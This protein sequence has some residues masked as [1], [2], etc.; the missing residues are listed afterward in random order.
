L[1][2]DLRALSTEIIID[3]IRRMAANAPVHAQRSLA[4][5]RSFFAWALQN[6][7]I[8]ENPLSAVVSPRPPP[9]R[10]RVLGLTEVRAVWRAAGDLGL[11]FGA[12]IALLVLTA[13]FREDAGALKVSE[14]TRDAEGEW[15]WRPASRVAK[16]DAMGIPLPPAATR[17]VEEG[18]ERRPRG[19]DFVFSTTGVT[20]ISG[21]SRAKRRLDRLMDGADFG[22]PMG[23]WR[24][25]DL[26]PSFA[27]LAAD[28][29]AIDPLVIEQALGRVSGYANPLAREWSRSERMV[30]EH[31]IALERWAA[32]VVAP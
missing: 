25:N 2:E 24:L 17:L 22:A 20:P 11:P 23:P 31:R 1:E 8:S 27:A 9:L 30:A 29:L 4:Y 26:R 10:N 3:L 16:G 14:L 15:I 7:L 21:W 5:A 6:G 12:P 19:S 32:L 18:L 13:T 28:I